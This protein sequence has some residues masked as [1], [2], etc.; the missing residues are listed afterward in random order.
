M[1]QAASDVMLK[2]RRP[3]EISVAGGVILSKIP[4]CGRGRA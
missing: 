1:R 2:Q 3:L 4:G